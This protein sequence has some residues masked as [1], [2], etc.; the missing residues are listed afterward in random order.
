VKN[1][2]MLGLAAVAA[3]SLMG[4]MGVASASASGKLC[5][6]SSDPCNSA[7]AN[8]DV[9]AGTQSGSGTLHDNNL[10]SNISCTGST[11]NDTITSNGNPITD[12]LTSLTFTG[13]TESVFHTSC[14]ATAQNLPWSTVISWNTGTHPPDGFVDITAGTLANGGVKVICSSVGYNCTWAAGDTIRLGVY[15]PTATTGTQVKAVNT[16][17]TSHDCGHTG[18]WNATYNVKDTTAGNVN[19]WIASS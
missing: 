6:N 17:L 19:V 5:Y 14:T 15:N 16:A 10:G 1:I 2:K 12:S 3:M 8:N 4:F 7:V 13:C 9:L 18:T 11:F